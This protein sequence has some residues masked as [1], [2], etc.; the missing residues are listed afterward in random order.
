MK[1]KRIHLSPGNV[2]EEG[3]ILVENGKITSVGNSVGS[4][5]GP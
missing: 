3:A 2:I 1:A 5:R 4:P